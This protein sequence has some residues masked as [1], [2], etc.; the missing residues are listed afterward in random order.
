MCP[1]CVYTAPRH[2]HHFFCI[3]HIDGLVQERRNSSALAMGLRLSCTNPSIWIYQI[4]FIARVKAWISSIMAKLFPA[5]GSCQWRVMKGQP[6]GKL[7]GKCWSLAADVSKTS[8]CKALSL[9]R[10]TKQNKDQNKE[11][12]FRKC[13]KFLNFRLYV[14]LM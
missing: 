5:F 10:A 3:F 11:P 1:S 4:M 9:F 2:G 6:S 7:L 8:Y 13:Y 12:V 14:Y